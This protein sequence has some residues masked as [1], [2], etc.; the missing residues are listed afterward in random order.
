V[1][2]A[3]EVDLLHGRVLGWPLVAESAG[4]HLRFIEAAY[5]G[6]T[7]KFR[8]VRA[9][10]GSWTDEIAAPE[11]FGRALLVLGR[12]ITDAGDPDL[13]E[14]AAALFDLALPAGARLTTPRAQGFVVL[15]CA[16]APETADRTFVM[17]SV[18]TNLH[19][20]FR[21]FARPGWP[22]PE[23]DM[24]TESALPL[25]AMIV[26]GQRL[27][28]VTMLAVGLQVLDWLIDVQTA[29]AGHLSLIGTTGWSHGVV[30]PQFDQLP[31]DA[32]ALLLAAEAALAA[33][34][35][36]RYSTTMERAYAW[37]LGSNDLGLKLA[38]P[39][40]GACHDRLTAGGIDADEGAQATLAWLV[41]VEHL[42]VLRTAVPSDGRA[43]ITTTPPVARPTRPGPVASLGR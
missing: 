2:R 42:R 28:A 43:T 37:F 4:R 10:D 34:G 11:T 24:P 21:S 7:R 18:A 38:D 5:D 17:R 16:A 9:M 33:T 39:A 41:A 29:P 23:H 13:A 12:T 32:T 6:S 30:K 40:R 1:A 15:A 22:W 19:A 26:A 3:L 31:I 35:K 14:R 8:S 27:G 36:P 25:R 20:R